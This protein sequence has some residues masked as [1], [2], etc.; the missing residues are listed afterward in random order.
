MT[1]RMAKDSKDKTL[2][3]T[4][5]ETVRPMWISDYHNGKVNYVAFHIPT[6]A[7]RSSSSSLLVTSADDKQENEALEL[8]CRLVDPYGSSPGPS[9][10]MYNVFM[11]ARA[12]ISNLDNHVLTTI[13]QIHLRALQHNKIGRNKYI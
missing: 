10:A 9:I 6:T 11:D 3:I 8:R 5:V 2:A 7:S 12:S 13:R 1:M 4:Y